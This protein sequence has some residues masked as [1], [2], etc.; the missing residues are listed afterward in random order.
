MDIPLA[1][2]HLLP[3]A[4][5]RRADD[6]AKLVE[7]W[8]DERPIPTEA[9]LL[10]AWESIQS[11]S[12]ASAAREAA[13]AALADKWAALPSWIRGPFGG[14]YDAAIRLLNAND[15]ETAADLIRYAD[16]PALYS[17]EQSAVFELVRAELLAALSGIPPV[18]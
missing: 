8:H 12:A 14:K 10:A 18:S 3:A 11:A 2:D 1:I 16:A 9:E 4:D 5:Y 6:Y 13:R 17:P 7:T 15:D